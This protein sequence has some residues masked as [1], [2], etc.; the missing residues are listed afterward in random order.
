MMNEM[1]LR[2]ILD[3]YPYEIVYCDRTNT[4][5]FLNAAAKKKYGDVIHAGGSLFSC[6]NERAKDKISRFLA[7]ADAGET[8][9]MFETLNKSTGEREFF[10]PV[11][12]E[13][14]I[15]IGYFERHE[16]CWDPTKP[17]APV[18]IYPI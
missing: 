4:I 1:Q 8:G 5:R 13:N 17:D 2:A 6:H 18:D 9:E 7:R 3:A 11:R 14:G 10:V 12:D 16:N 15:V